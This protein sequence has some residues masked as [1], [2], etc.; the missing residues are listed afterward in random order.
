MVEA[1]ARLPVTALVIAFDEAIHIARCLDRL[2]PFVE[3]VVVVDS[4]SRDDTVAIARAHGAE[5]VQHAF[6]THAA[7]VNH[8]IGVAAATTPWTLRIDADEYFEPGALT[9]LGAFLRDQPAE[10]T[11]V[12]LRRK[13]IFR[14]RWIRHGRYYP[15]VLLRCWRTG[16]A[17]CERRHMDEH[18]VLTAG[19]AAAFAGGDFVDHNLKDIDDWTAKHNRYATLAMVD[20]MVR[21]FGLAPEDE[22]VS[23]TG[24]A[25]KRNRVLKQ[26]VYGRAPLFLRA[27][28]LYLYR[29]VVRLGFLDGRAGFLYHTLHGLWVHLLIDAKIDEARTL[30][31]REGPE[32]FRRHLRDRHGITL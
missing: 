30:I 17:V 3:R 27:V 7:Q 11:G 22:R 10:V 18:M 19:R 28:L 25:A 20:A 4:Y 15:V 13:F 9:A 29:Y 26:S 12:T 31:R 14:D 2:V 16:K 23:A 1:A 24:G 8:A 32:A 6:T 21:E 5:V